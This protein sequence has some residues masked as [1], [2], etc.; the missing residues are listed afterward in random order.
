M[1]DSPTKSRQQPYSNL[2]ETLQKPYSNLTA[3]C[4]RSHRVRECDFGYVL[5]FNLLCVLNVPQHLNS[6]RFKRCVL[7]T[8]QFVGWLSKLGS[9][10]R[11]SSPNGRQWSPHMLARPHCGGYG[12]EIRGS[13]ASA[14]RP[15][16]QT[17]IY[18]PRPV[19]LRFWPTA[20]ALHPMN[21]RRGAGDHANMIDQCGTVARITGLARSTINRGENDLDAIRSRTDSQTPCRAGDKGRSRAA[22]DLGIEEYG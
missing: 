1:P 9:A 17:I 8:V 2:T 10:G 19:H 11:L 7:T 3:T 15:V 20:V 21:V 13:P 4:I 5:T 6:R 18:A 22:S 14:G 12:I 16:A